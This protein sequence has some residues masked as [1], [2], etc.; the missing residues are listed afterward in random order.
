MSQPYELFGV[1]VHTSQETALAQAQAEPYTPV[2]LVT[3]G[4]T[5]RPVS[6]EDTVMHG[7]QDMVARYAAT[8]LADPLEGSDPNGRR[9]NVHQA[10]EAVLHHLA[11]AGALL[12]PHAAVHLAASARTAAEQHEPGS[13]YTSPL[14]TLAVDR[15]KLRYYGALGL[16]RRDEA[17]HSRELSPLIELFA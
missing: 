1:N 15:L 17:K 7:L 13:V 8:G 4:A 6:F 12:T 5:L 10:K 11:Y 2:V 14:E 3:A 16:R 9:V